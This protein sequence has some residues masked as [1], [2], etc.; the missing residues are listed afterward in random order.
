MVLYVGYDLRGSGQPPTA[1]K[2]NNENDCALLCIA[3]FGC[4]GFVFIPSSKNC[5]LKKSHGSA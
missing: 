4:K 3:T 1:V 2:K 5:Y